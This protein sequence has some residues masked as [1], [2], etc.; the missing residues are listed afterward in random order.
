M[1]YGKYL[2]SFYSIREKLF[3]AFLTRLVCAKHKLKCVLKKRI[4]SVGNMN[5]RKYFRFKKVLGSFKIEFI[6]ELKMHSANIT[7]ACH[8]KVRN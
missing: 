2:L 6:L 1:L 7:K 3:T 8:Q 5:V 4:G